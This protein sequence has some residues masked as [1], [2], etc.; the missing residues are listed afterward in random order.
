[1]QQLTQIKNVSENRMFSLDPQQ[2]WY[3]QEYCVGAIDGTHILYLHVAYYITGYKGMVRLGMAQ[4]G[5]VDS[6]ATRATKPEMNL[7]GDIK[8]YL[9][10]PVLALRKGGGRITNKRRY[11]DLISNND[12]YIFTLLQSLRSLFLIIILGQMNCSI[13]QGMGIEEKTKKKFLVKRRHLEMT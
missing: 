4:L 11:I 9:V 2:Q 5:N 3:F 6:V 1:M 12:Y 7:F 13:L 10:V 8:N